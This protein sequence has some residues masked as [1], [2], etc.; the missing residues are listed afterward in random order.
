MPLLNPGLVGREV[1]D[2]G[3]YLSHVSFLGLGCQ[4]STLDLA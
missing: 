1:A 3:S 2:W 4:H